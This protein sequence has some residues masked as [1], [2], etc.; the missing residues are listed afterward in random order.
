MY[1]NPISVLFEGCN[2]VYISS[3]QGYTRGYTR[4]YTLLKSYLGKNITENFNN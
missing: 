4:G 2:F 1:T 3:V